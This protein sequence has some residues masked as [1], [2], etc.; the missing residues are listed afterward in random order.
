MRA[1][2]T[3]TEACDLMLPLMSEYLFSDLTVAA[4]TDDALIFCDI[5]ERFTP[6]NGW[7]N[8]DQNRLVI[9]WGETYNGIK[10]AN[11][12]ISYIDKVEGLDESIKNEYLGRASS[13]LSL[14]KFVLPIWRCTFCVKNYRSTKTGL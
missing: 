9:F 10:Y 1:Y 4:K 12:I 11:T 14:F 2:W 5:N 8:F 7:Y 13:C 6:N 3:N